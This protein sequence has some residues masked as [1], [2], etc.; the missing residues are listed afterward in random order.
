MARMKMDAV[1]HDYPEY[2]MHLADLYL[3]L[4]NQ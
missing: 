1:I 4:A 2:G 3:T